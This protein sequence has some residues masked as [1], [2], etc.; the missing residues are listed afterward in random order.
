MKTITQAIQEVLDSAPEAGFCFDKGLLNL[1]AFAKVINKDIEKRTFKKVQHASL[2]TALAR[3][4]SSSKKEG[5]VSKIKFEYIK[6]ITPVVQVVYK[7]TSTL[8][9]SI[10]DFQLRFENFITSEWYVWSSR[11]NDIVI[12]TSLQVFEKL[13]SFIKNSQPENLVE[14]LVTISL[15]VSDSY[16]QESGILY[17]ITRLFAR[18]KIP[19]VDL[20][21]NPGEIEIML[22]KKY[23][24]E[25]LE[26]LERK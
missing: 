4:Q 10:L 24:I 16:Q 7:K 8:S 22:H 6:V 15:G 19:I 1:S 17:S 2:V 26:L 11:K 18:R 3:L 12:S 14:D 23:L 9:N 5:V 13:Q 25:A 20:I 21:S